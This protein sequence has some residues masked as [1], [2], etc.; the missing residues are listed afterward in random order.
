[1]KKFL[2]KFFKIVFLFWV[3]SIILTVCIYSFFKK[4]LY[5]DYELSEVLSKKKV[6][7][8]YP[9]KINT[10]FVGSS[11]TYRQIIPHVFDSITNNTSF[12]LGF[13]GLFPYR[14][15][16]MLTEVLKTKK[17][18]EIQNIFIELGPPDLIADNYRNNPYI[19]SI[20]F[21]K[22]SAAIETSTNENLSAS[23]RLSI[24]RYWNLCL[25]YKY[26][27]FSLS[28]YIDALMFNNTNTTQTNYK[29]D[30]LIASTKGFIDLNT[31]EVQLN[32]GKL[33]KIR[34]NFIKHGNAIDSAIIKK[35][36]AAYKFY[37]PDRFTNF[38]IA[39]AKNLRK[40]GKN[41]CFIIPPRK[42][43]FTKYSLYEKDILAKEG[44]KIYNLSDPKL[45]PQ[46][47]TY[48]LSYNKTHLNYNGAVLYTTVLANQIK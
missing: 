23:A 34:K 39:Y 45:Y 6:Y 18:E 21:K 48:D 42:L 29:Y 25:L 20:N 8:N 43:L 5:A 4:D 15:Y 46:F 33:D 36:S 12:N 10:V 41:V 16:D 31:Q 3:L 2:I 44:F 19:Y 35:Y 7:E 47:Y 26:S 17:S 22:Y 28:K 11:L 38:V 40:Q 32:N 30:S 1:M 24:F 9:Q 37:A 27:G 13:E 14:S